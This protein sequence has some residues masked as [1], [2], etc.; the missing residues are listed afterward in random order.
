[1]ICTE[2]A[3]SLPGH[4]AL[5][6]VPA[7]PGLAELCSVTSLTPSIRRRRTR[8]WATAVWLVAHPLR[9][10]IGTLPG[11]VAEVTV[12]VAAVPDLADVE[13]AP[14]EV[15]ELTEPLREEIDT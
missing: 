2:N 5:P 9:V 10:K 12:V 4:P 1:M 7:D 11:G 6:P 8:V 3:G 13:A 15:P 14:V